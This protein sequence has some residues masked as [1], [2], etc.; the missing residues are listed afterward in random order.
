MPTS[1]I[2]TIKRAGESVVKAKKS[3]QASV[4]GDGGTGFA[5]TLLSLQHSAGNRAVR[6]LIQAKLTLSP[7]HDRYEKEADHVAQQAM[8]KPK[9]GEVAEHGPTQDALQRNPLAE[10][11][12]PLT[13]PRVVLKD[14]DTIRRSPEH[15]QGEGAAAQPVGH[16][17]EKKLEENRGA[18]KPLPPE[19]RV[20][21][22][23]K[24][25]VDFR[26]VRLH[27]GNAANKLAR[28]IGAEAFTSGK[29]IYVG[30]GKLQPHSEKGQHL[31]AHELTHVVQQSAGVQRRSD[32]A[33][34]DD[35]API[36]HINRKKV[37]RQLDFLRLKRKNARI[38]K[39]TLGKMK[40]MR[41]SMGDPLAHSWME[42]GKTSK[43][44]EPAES[45]GWWPS[46]GEEMASS[47]AQGVPGLLNAMGKAP[48]SSRT[49]D[50]HQGEKPD[51]EFQPVAEIDQDSKY[52]KLLDDVTKRARDF[53]NSFK[54]RWSWR[55]RWG[56][57][58]ANFMHKM[59]MKL[60]L[61]PPKKK[62]PMMV[63]PK[64]LMAKAA[65]ERLQSAEEFDRVQKAFAKY[66]DQGGVSL[67][68]LLKSSDLD[69]GDFA[70]VFQDV[71]PEEENARAEILA[72]LNPKTTKEEILEHAH[73][74]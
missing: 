7:G 14:D 67:N 45:Y 65:Q 21:M 32:S 10:S 60:K 28:S 34:Y 30:E 27:T 51:E 38:V 61:E 20:E 69:L 66:A 59:M 2:S 50:P 22:E 53:A 9:A 42:A 23:S 47:T 1:R 70:R 13:K 41:K 49:R 40:I 3:A 5:R 25:G 46:K 31:L 72:M 73:A 52:E 15:Q 57:N 17:L 8:N 18:G 44:W 54:D 4:Q 35:G 63:N 37:Q 62:M 43:G 16:A 24:F 12:T 26:G 29:D 33:A 39:E 68:D 74:R 58:S 48:R 19:T 36:N 71:T 6:R 11:I 56:A 55:N 64:L